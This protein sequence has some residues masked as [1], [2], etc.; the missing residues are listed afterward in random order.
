MP[1]II[2]V[3]G[4]DIVISNHATSA[5]ISD[6]TDFGNVAQVGGRKTHI[7]SVENTGT[8]DLILDGIHP[9]VLNDTTAFTA[10]A[11]P[12][13]TIEPGGI[14]TFKILFDPPLDQLYVALI[15][16]SNNSS[17]D[18]PYEFR[19]EG[20]GIICTNTRNRRILTGW[21]DRITKNVRISNNKWADYNCKHKAW[22]DLK[23]L[24]RLGYIC[25]NEL[26]N[27]PNI[28]DYQDLISEKDFSC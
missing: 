18:N 25:A 26:P 7:F 10:L 21:V 23:E 4:N 2:V 28:D 9:V 16:I 22:N 8:S 17:S 20:N 11:Q 27:E 1:A 15:T 14:S 6:D 5:K 24:S 3:S 12:R 19:L 13:V